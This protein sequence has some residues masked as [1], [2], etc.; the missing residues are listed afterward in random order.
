MLTRE[1]EIPSNG[2]TTDY[3]AVYDSAAYYHSKF[4]PGSGMS[5]NPS[6]LSTHIHI[7]A[8]LQIELTLHDVLPQHPLTKGHTVHQIKNPK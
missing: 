6:N 7:S 3:Q 2:I 8:A 4:K 1:I 5:L